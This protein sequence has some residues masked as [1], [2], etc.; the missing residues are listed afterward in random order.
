MPKG[1]E[2]LHS[3][4]FIDLLPERIYKINISREDQSRIEEIKATLVENPELEEIMHNLA[5][6]LP[7][8]MR[9]D[10]SE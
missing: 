6:T 9:G 10:W 5:M 2:N 7:P 4:I 3:K 1:I 8:D